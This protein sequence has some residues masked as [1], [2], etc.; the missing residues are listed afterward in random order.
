ML[1]SHLLSSYG[2]SSFTHLANNRFWVSFS[3]DTII[4]LDPLKMNSHMTDS[5]M[6]FVPTITWKIISVRI[7]SFDSIL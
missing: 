2:K 1:K 5:P 6:V 3:A 7:Y 4:R